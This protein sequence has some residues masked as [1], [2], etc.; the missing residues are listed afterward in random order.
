VLPAGEKGYNYYPTPADE[1]F[2]P[3]G[4]GK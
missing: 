4:G 2:H 1:G 3:Q